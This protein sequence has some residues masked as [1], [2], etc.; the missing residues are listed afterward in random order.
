[1][2][3]QSSN[4]K[5][6]E[7]TKNCK[8]RRVNLSSLRVVKTPEGKRFC[9]WCMSVELHHGNQKYCSSACSDSAMAWANPQKEDA[10]KFLLARQDYKCASCGFDYKPAMQEVIAHAR[11]HSKVSCDWDT[12]PWHYFKRLKD[13]VM[14]DRKPE[15]DHIIPIFKGG[16]SLGLANT[17]VKCYLCHKAKTKKDLSKE[18]K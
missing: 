17:E 15:V 5:V 12:L 8:E 10:L 7:L 14:P 6:E 4:P 9:V 11:H 18:P 16:C 3:K 13:R 2:Y 1:M